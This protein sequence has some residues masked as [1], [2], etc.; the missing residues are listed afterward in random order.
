M[1]QNAISLSP[2]TDT[3]LSVTFI[4]YHFNY[5]FSSWYGCASLIWK[6]KVQIVLNNKIY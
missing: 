3:I 1:Y 6:Y 5:Y 2:E 4:Q